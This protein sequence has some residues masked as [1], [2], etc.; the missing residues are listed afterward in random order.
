MS[1][2]AV[3]RGEALLRRMEKSDSVSFYGARTV[4][5][6]LCAEVSKASLKDKI[7]AECRTFKHVSGLLE[8]LFEEL[9][10]VDT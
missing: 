4:I 1:N 10:R 8:S 3:N 7:I 6:D 2:E 9:D 5:R